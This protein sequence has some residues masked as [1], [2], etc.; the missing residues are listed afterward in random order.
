MFGLEVQPFELSGSGLVSVG[1]SDTVGVCVSQFVS[2]LVWRSMT[3]DGL[4]DGTSGH[5]GIAQT[6]T[7]INKVVHYQYQCKSNLWCSKSNTASL[8]NRALMPRT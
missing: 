3:G 1:V 4:T 7:L 6:H 8:F 2:Q 5:G